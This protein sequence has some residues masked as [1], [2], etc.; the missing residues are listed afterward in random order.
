[1]MSRRSLS[2]AAQAAGFLLMTPA[3]F[4]ADAAPV[5]RAQIEAVLPQ[6]EQLVQKAI[7]EAAA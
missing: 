1:M 7:S 5:T 3:A 4:A 6:F 2:I